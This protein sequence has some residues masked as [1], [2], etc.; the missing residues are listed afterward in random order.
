M[1]R[2]V[3]DSFKAVTKRGS[4]VGGLLLG[5]VTHSDNRTVFV[6]N[7]ESVVCDYSRGPLYLLA[8]PDKDRL[9][10][11]LER[12]KS[13]PLSPVGFFRSNTRNE[14]VL[15]EDDLALAQELFSDPNQVFLLVKPFA[16]RPSAAGLFIWEDGRIQAAKITFGAEPKDYEGYAFLLQHFFNLDFGPQIPFEAAI[17][18]RINPKRMQRAV[19]S[20][21][22]SATL[23]RRPGG[24][25][26]RPQSGVARR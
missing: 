4:E 22:A 26:R 9:R 10:E 23:G 6:E 12:L 1:E 25:S 7:Y 13:S 19:S 18:T 11:A 17:K 2:E 8:D 21:G 3:I 5:R 16:M 24:P 15:D 20:P 14:L